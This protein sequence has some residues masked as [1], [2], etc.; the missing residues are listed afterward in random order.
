MVAVEHFLILLDIRRVLR[1]DV[2]LGENRGYRTFGLARTT[3]DAFVGMDVKLVLNLIDTVH[4]TDIYTGAVLHPNACFDDH[5]SHPALPP[6][7]AV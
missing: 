3:V 4:R 1:R 5:I 7:E 2:F 6:N